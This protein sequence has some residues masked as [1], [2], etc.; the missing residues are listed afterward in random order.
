MPIPPAR[1]R[2][3]F[4]AGDKREVVARRA[5]LDRVAF[6]VP[7]ACRETAARLGL[8]LDRDRVTRRVGGPVAQRILAHEPGPTW[9]SM[10]DPGANEG[11]EPPVLA[12]SNDLISRRLLLDALHRNCQLGHTGVLLSAHGLA[13]RRLHNPTLASGRRKLA[14][15]VVRRLQRDVSS[16]PQLDQKV[17]NLDRSDNHRERIPSFEGL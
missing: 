1:S 9:T 16:A 7:R 15:A 3:C 11:R 4:A 14:P 17:P 5:D 13:P 6:L 10:C 8:S 2:C 12:S